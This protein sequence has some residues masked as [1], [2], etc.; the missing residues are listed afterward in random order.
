[1]NV[2][3][4]WQTL[5]SF[6]RGAK[7]LSKLY[8]AWEFKFRCRRKRYQLQEVSREGWTSLV[9]LLNMRKNKGCWDLI[10]GMYQ[11][12][13]SPVF[14]DGGSLLWVKKRQTNKN[15]DLFVDFKSIK[16]KFFF[17][18]VDLL[19]KLKLP[20]KCLTKMIFYLKINKYSFIQQIFTKH[21]LCSSCF[22]VVLIPW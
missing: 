18:P 3:I 20:L 5:S 8:G 16:K 2:N 13:V 1:M 4:Y 22:D 15:K 11:I 21:L 12:A 19:G 6:C 7:K 9:N 10:R 14:A 17:N